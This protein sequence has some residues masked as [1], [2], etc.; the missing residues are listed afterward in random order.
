MSMENTNSY[1]EGFIT[2]KIGK[3]RIMANGRHTLYVDGN[4]H[5]NNSDG[6]RSSNPVIVRGVNYNATLH[7]QDYGNGYEL[8][9]NEHGRTYDAYYFSRA[10]KYGRNDGVSDS[11]RDVL[12]KEMT[13]A[14]LKW[15]AENPT[16]PILAG[17]HEEEY[18]FACMQNKIA[19]L[20]AEIAKLESEQTTCALKI[21]SYKRSL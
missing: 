6:S 2:T 4:F 17:I 19:G 21:D 18:N 10:G 8:M 15:I 11:A 16:A 14:A 5:T 7:M 12:I 9:K 1:P 13:A 20:K 3:F